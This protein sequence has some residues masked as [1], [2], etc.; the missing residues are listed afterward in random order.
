MMGYELESEEDVDPEQKQLVNLIMMKKP[1]R[2]SKCTSTC[3]L[4][5]V[6]QRIKQVLHKLLQYNRTHLELLLKTLVNMCDWNYCCNTTTD[7]YVPANSSATLNLG[8]VS[9]IGVAELQRD[10]NSYHTSRRNG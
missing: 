6:L 4:I 5:L 8:R 1:K 7:Y 2:K 3:R 10:C 9:S